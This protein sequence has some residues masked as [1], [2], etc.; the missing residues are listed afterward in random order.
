[1]GGAA[2]AGDAAAGAAVGGLVKPWRVRL[3]DLPFSAVEWVVT[4]EDMHKVGPW[5][6]GGGG[7]HRSDVPN[8]DTAAPTR[9]ARPLPSSSLPWP[10]HACPP[11]LWCLS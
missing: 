5:G 3:V 7:T 1:M 6:G 10:R 8:E 2:A 11:P 9:Q 4:E